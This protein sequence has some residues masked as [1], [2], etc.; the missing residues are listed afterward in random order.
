MVNLPSDQYEVYV[1]D[2]KA[3]EFVVDSAEA[4]TEIYYDI[5]A[6]Y[7][8]R[9]SGKIDMDTRIGKKGIKMSVYRKSGEQ[10]RYFRYTG[11]M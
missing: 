8:Y 7:L 3:G 4:N 9:V 6:S 1:A 2:E 5:H 11:K 10:W